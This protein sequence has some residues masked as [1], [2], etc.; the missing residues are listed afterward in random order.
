M[1]IQQ[2]DYQI[3]NAPSA[4]DSIWGRGILR[5]AR[6]KY[7]FA[8]DGGAISTI[9]PG[10]V[11]N[12]TIPDNAVIVAGTINATTACTS[13]ASATISV[14]TSAG[15]S[16]AAMLA[17]TAVA[18]FSADAIINAVPVFATPV[19]MTAE[20]RITFSIAVAAL[21]AGVIEATLFYFVADA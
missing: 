18:S 7:D 6:A 3:A 12:A 19:K 14:G 17:L 1:T 15:S 20:G 8:V 11:V 13:G 21:T 4:A 5:T 16:T 2:T 9:T 10:S